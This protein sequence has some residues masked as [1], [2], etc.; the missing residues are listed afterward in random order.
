MPLMP[1]AEIFWKHIFKKNAQ[2]LGINLLCINQIHVRLHPV[3]FLQWMDLFPLY[4]LLHIKSEH[5]SGYMDR[6]NAA[7]MY[8]MINL[9]CKQTHLPKGKQVLHKQTGNNLRQHPDE[10]EIKIFLERSTVCTGDLF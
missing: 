9:L 6:I 2:S 7:E 10:G 5:T 3:A 8:I 1:W 4:S